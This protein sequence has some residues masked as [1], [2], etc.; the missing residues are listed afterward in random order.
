VEPGGLL[1]KNED[2]REELYRIRQNRVST[3]VRENVIEA[4]LSN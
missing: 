1:K 4:S 3:D 2:Y